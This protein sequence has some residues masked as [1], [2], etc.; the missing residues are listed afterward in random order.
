MGTRSALQKCNQITAVICC[1]SGAQ[2]SVS[3]VDRQNSAASI[4]GSDYKGISAEVIQL[5][6][7]GSRNT[8]L[9]T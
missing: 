2:E 8:Q 7:W 6:V 4:N 9:Y 5:S 1:D 3:K